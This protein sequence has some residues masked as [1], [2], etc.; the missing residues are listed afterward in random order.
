MC[1]RC[2]ACVVCGACRGR[3]IFEGILRN[4]PKRLDLWS[5]YI[6]QELKAGEQAR[7]RSLFER[8]TH[9]SL[10]PKKMRFLFRWG[11]DSESSAW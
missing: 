6:D 2:A 11:Q 8:A 5:V 4:Y 3:S 1:V 7:I 9:L 10:P